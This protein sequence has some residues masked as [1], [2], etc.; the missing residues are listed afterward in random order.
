LYQGFTVE[1]FSLPFDLIEWVLAE[2]LWIKLDESGLEG[3]TLTTHI[4]KQQKSLYSL[5]LTEQEA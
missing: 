5:Q 3:A 4:Y 1:Q 2:I